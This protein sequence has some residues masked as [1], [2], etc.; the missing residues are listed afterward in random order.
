MVS[1]CCLQCVLYI[2]VVVAWATLHFRYPFSPNCALPWFQREQLLFLFYCLVF[3]LC[4]PYKFNEVE[5][6]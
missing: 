4:Q 3:V 5:I 6:G 2:V 1:I